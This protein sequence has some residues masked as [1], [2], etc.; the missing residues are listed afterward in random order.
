MTTADSHDWRKI[1]TAPR[2]GSRIVVAVRASEQGPAEVDVVCWS[3]AE[4]A[5]EEGWVAAD[6]RPGLSLIYAEAELT[7][8]MPL[9]DPQPSLGSLRERLNPA[10]EA[11]SG[12]EMDGSSI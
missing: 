6:S 10:A 5:A 2:D 8:W 12:G 7:G 4:G 11:K 3:C 1:A 9:P